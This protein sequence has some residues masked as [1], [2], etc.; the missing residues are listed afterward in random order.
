M[1]R[2]SMIGDGEKVKSSSFTP[3]AGPWYAIYMATN[4]QPVQL[5]AEQLRLL[6]EWSSR[7]GK[8]PQELLAE[9]SA[10]I[11]PPQ[12]RR[13]RMENTARPCRNACL[14]RA[15]WAAFPVDRLI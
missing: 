3:P 14:A 11:A 5:T 7:T 15:C 12:I 2:P 10:S 8:P 1:H 13:L 9:R 6:G 4:D